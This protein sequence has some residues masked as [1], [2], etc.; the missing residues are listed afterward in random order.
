M[1][2]E[3]I[4]DLEK[5]DLIEVVFVEINL[6]PHNVY[7]VV[8]LYV[9]ADLVAYFETVEQRSLF[10]EI[11]IIFAKLFQIIFCLPIERHPLILVCLSY[12]SLLFFKAW[13]DKEEREVLLS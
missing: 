3:K 8:L 7:I 6:H 12:F 4:V 9:G 2:N 5:P 11:F 13:S 10:L 1:S